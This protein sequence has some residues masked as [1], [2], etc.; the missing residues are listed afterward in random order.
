[1]PKGVVLVRLCSKNLEM[2]KRVS[3]RSKL[4]GS[5][6]SKITGITLPM[7]RSGHTLSTYCMLAITAGPTGFKYRLVDNYFQSHCTREE[8]D[9]LVK[10]SPLAKD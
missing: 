9:A 6:C 10:D 1:M 5:S 2:L 8:C 4:N 7:R 3:G